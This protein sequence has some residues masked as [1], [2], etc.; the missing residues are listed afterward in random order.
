M[1]LLE[2]REHAE[3]LGLVVVTTVVNTT[4][5]T[6]RQ[7]LRLRFRNTLQPGIRV[8]IEEF[9]RWAGEQS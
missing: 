3:A 4:F 7:R 9:R 6:H 5:G 1:N 2:A 8:P